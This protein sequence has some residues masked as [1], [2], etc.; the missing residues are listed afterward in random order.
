MVHLFRHSLD[1]LY[2]LRVATGSETGFRVLE[3]RNPPEIPP[4]QESSK[5]PY[6]GYVQASHPYPRRPPK[7]SCCLK[8]QSRQ[9][10]HTPVGA[11]LST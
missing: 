1:V 11:A 10:W 5:K 4:T 9:D 7:W 8:S 6:E 2:V 3:I